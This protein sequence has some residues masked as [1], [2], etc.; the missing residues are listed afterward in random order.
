[1]FSM[2]QKFTRRLPIGERAL[3]VLKQLAKNESAAAGVMFAVSLIAVVPAIGVAVDYARIVQFKTA[4]QNAVDSA[5]LAG[6]SA[7]T[8]PTAASAGVTTATSYLAKAVGALPG[9][10]G[11]TT[12]TP[13]TSTITYQS[14]A[15]GYAVSVTATG[16]IDTMILSKVMSSMS[17][18]VAAK[19]VNPHITLTIKASLANSDAWDNNIV[20]WYAVPLDGSVPPASVFTSQAMIY[21]NNPAKAAQ[22]PA[23]LTI[24]IAASQNLGFALKNVTGGLHYYSKN[25]YGASG[26]SSNWMYS[27]LQPPSKKT[28]ASVTQNC[29]VET[30][31]VSSV[32]AQNPNATA[33]D[34][35]KAPSSGSCFSTTPGT[36]TKNLALDCANSSN[37]GKTIRY[38]FNDMG[39][40]SDDHDYNDAAFNVTCPAAVTGVPS[41][42]ALIQ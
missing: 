16:S 35:P 19:A 2:I 3:A 21:D 36:Y 27:H 30:K 22:N 17:V 31:D 23:Q 13:T 37:A 34:M 11:V 9:N 39:G 18:S 32:V 26:N 14:G 1:M 20:Y 7:Y 24:D 41:G 12:P 10:K 4:L 42:V 29:L 40:G 15:V 8:G 6:A 38:Y 5:A 25:S 28:Y 33:A